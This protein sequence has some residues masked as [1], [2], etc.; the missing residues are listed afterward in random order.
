MAT[1]AYDRRALEDLDRLTDFLIGENPSAA[2]DVLLLIRSAID[3][4]QMH[5]LIGRPV[6]GD[7]RELIISHGKTGYIAL[8][9]FRKPAN[10]VQVRA[11]RHQREADFE[12]D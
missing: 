11:I 9:H 1:L 4:L 5:P 7:L 3:L 12:E 2:E 10:H 6:P 8:Y